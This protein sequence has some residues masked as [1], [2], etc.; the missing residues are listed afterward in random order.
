[1]SCCQC[2]KGRLRDTYTC[3]YCWFLQ[4]NNMPRC[5]LD[6]KA[7][8]VMYMQVLGSAGHQCSCDVW[9]AGVIMYILLSGYPPFN[10]PNERAILKQVKRGQY[11]FAGLHCKPFAVLWQT[12]QESQIQLSQKHV[13]FVNSRHEHKRVCIRGICSKVQGK[14]K[15]HVKT[16][17]STPVYS[18]QMHSRH[19][20]LAVKHI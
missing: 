19:R 8:H 1:M 20:L 2:I 5:A 7:S 12:T 16:R 17:M 3:K 13:M 15:K 9:S 18:C 11:T 10:G 4:T 6:L 14:C